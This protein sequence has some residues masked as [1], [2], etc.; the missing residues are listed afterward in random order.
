MG[1]TVWFRV[2]EG[3]LT[4]HVI[5]ED[6]GGHGIGVGDVNGDGRADVLGPDGWF[7]APEDPLKGQ[8]IHRAE[9]SM[10]S[11]GISIIAHDFD[12][13]GLTDVFWGMGHD[14]GLYW[15]KQ[16]RDE[17]GQ[18]TWTRRVVDETWSQAHGLTLADLDGDGAMEAITGKRRFAHN[19]KDPGAGGTAGALTRGPA[20]SAP[21]GTAPSR[22]KSPG[23]RAPSMPRGSNGTDG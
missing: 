3:T 23:E 22:V 13:D 8:W 6:R 15:L 12:R 5:S 19:G 7:E 18:R 4:P 2:N 20:C 17:E 9:W 14:Y 21:G 11:A 1:R 10:G 16:S